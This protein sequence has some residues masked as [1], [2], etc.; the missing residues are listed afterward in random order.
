V[1]EDDEHEEHP[2]RGGR[3]DEQ[4]DSYDLARD[5]EH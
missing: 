1:H 5:R 2:E 4:V 3:H